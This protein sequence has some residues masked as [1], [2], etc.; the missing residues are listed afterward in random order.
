MNLSSMHLAELIEVLH[1]VRIR[2]SG[3]VASGG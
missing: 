2:Q 3:A 1:G